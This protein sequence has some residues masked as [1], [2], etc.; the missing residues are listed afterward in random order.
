M[1]RWTSLAALLLAFSLPAQAISVAGYA[2]R[3]DVTVGESFSVNVVVVNDQP[4]AISGFRVVVQR[5][6]D[7]GNLVNLG[8]ATCAPASCAVGSQIT[9]NPGNLQPGESFT[10][11]FKTS[12]ASAAGTP[13]HTVTFPVTIT[14]GVGTTI[15]TTSVVVHSKG[16][17]ATATSQRL[18]LS[19]STANLSPGEEAIVTATLGNTSTVT[20]SFDNQLSIA[21]PI[22]LEIV[23]SRGGTVSGQQISWAIGALLPQQVLRRQV[24]V[25]AGTAIAPAALAVTATVQDSVQTSSERHV[26]AIQFA[27]AL[28]VFIETNRVSAIN[29]GAVRVLLRVENRSSGMLNA[30][31][32]RS[33]IPDGSSS[34]NGSHDPTACE[35][36]CNGLDEMVWS[37]GNLPAG[38][39]RS[40]SHIVY[41]WGSTNDPVMPGE[42]LRLEAVAASAA[43]RA[44]AT[45]DI[46]LPTGY[47]LDVMIDANLDH[48]MAGAVTPVELRVG[49]RTA[50]TSAGTVV[51]V[52]LP[53][54]VDLVDAGGATVVG[55]QLT[56]SIGGLAA[57]DGVVRTIGIAGF[58][59][60]RIFAHGFDSAPVPPLPGETQP[61]GG[62]LLATATNTAGA[63][64][65]NRRQLTRRIA[66]PDPL[67]LAIR[68]APDPV[69]YNGVLQAEV[70]VGNTGGTALLGTVVRFRLPS[71]IDSAF[72]ITG[73]GGECGWGCDN[74]RIVEWT[75]G[76]L[77]PGASRT[78]MLSMVAST[79]AGSVLDF[80]GWASANNGAVN[81][82]A[83]A[84]AST[85]AQR[86]MALAMGIDTDPLSSGATATYTLGY[87]NRSGVV[88]AAT[89][90]RLALPAGVGF[91]SASDGGTFANGD[92]V[93]T[94]G[95]LAAGQS[96]W[97]E[98]RVQVGN[99]SAGSLL[100]AAAALR[101]NAGRTSRYVMVTPVETA[102]PLAKVSIA[103]NPDPVLPNGM[104][105]AEITA[106]NASDDDLF[107]T[108]LTLRL[109][110]GGIDRADYISDG[111][112]GECGWGCGTAGQSIVWNLGALPRG[113]TRTRSAALWTQGNL[114]SGE[115]LEFDVSTSAN[116]GLDTTRR[117]A[118]VAIR[119]TRS[120]DLANTAG[121][122]PVNA[123]GT[124]NRVLTYG[125]RT[126][127]ALGA[128]TLRLPVPPGASLLSASDGGTLSSGDVIWSL[129]SL[130]SGAGGQRTATF[131][132]G[133]LPNGTLLDAAASADAG[134]AGRTRAGATSRVSSGVPLD[135]VATQTTA[136]PVPNSN[137]DIE[138]AISNFG[139]G[140]LF[141]AV[142]KL[143]LPSGLNQATN[144]SDGGTGACS[145]SNCDGT[146]VSWT[147]GTI[148][149]GATV[150]RNLR[151]TIP[152]GAARGSVLPFSAWVDATDG[153]TPYQSRYPMALRVQ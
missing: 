12:L 5:P 3:S 110:T 54:G 59:P 23:D 27:P 76:T 145:S 14:E 150:R 135:L 29:D 64:Q 88:Q 13:G 26:V 9:W 52:R 55:R 111:G 133:N 34:R 50:S 112:L 16:A 37:L 132:V 98:V 119:S 49:N 36:G 144:I 74:G 92:V 33:R 65:H 152:S 31:T 51:G 18:R 17:N 102:A 141:D 86:P 19:S 99:P 81:A 46:D 114:S 108:T 89:E 73:G 42:S 138:L 21:L 106:A 118:A 80:Q 44:V 101:D 66:T 78:R 113:A 30:V 8:D 84:L 125:N 7:T 15:A 140:D 67:T 82:R 24:V 10:A 123:N 56:W 134:T 11:S 105:A 1:K 41:P 87:G 149:P 129:A 63:M 137:V 151:V 130:A 62:P 121:R 122:D 127:S 93:W 4:T 75:I 70:V 116:D 83:D 153:A 128:T 95:T 142:L 109:T 39:S 136:T 148:T 38:A 147:V 47:P 72:N 58:R 28:R 53:D 43:Q 79:T 91:A 60:D 117:R 139:T 126:A 115:L 90:L 6:A 77:P 22:G 40:V 131:Q 2:S 25:R 146:M 68:V 96:G 143:R 61:L 120:L 45:A 71:G 103:L 57:G 100:R 85:A 107:D 97:R 32:L 69:I 104:F 35:N 20:N 124:L 94:I 48:V